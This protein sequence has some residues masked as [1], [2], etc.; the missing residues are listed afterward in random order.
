MVSA[1]LVVAAGG[2]ALLTQVDPTAD[3]A[4]LVAGSVL[5]SLGI[6]PTVTLG[7]DLIVG[8]APP[9]QAGAASAISE[10]GNELGLSLGVAVI[11]S[12]GTAVYRSDLADAMPAGV[13]ASISETAR[14]TLGGAVASAGTLP[15]ALGA[16]LVDAA[17]AAFTNGLQIAATCS[18]AVAILLAVLAGLLLRPSR[19][20]AEPSGTS[21]D[22]EGTTC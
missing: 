16:D 6:S 14:D 8:A 21:D 2:F 11:G 15:G 22:P 10:T 9:E 12:I 3:L 17:R 5:F 18:A 19:R 4:V 20:A 13:P 1:G 7:T